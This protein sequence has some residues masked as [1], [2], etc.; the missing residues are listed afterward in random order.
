MSTTI[1]KMSLQIIKK[2]YLYQL[3]ISFLIAL[4]GV[5]L[6]GFI[7]RIDDYSQ[8]RLILLSIIGALIFTTINAIINALNFVYNKSKNIT[9]SF[10]LPIMIWALLL[11]FGLTELMESKGFIT[12]DWLILIL[13]IEPILYHLILKKA[14]GNNVS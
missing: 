10:L 4:I 12:S 13:W 8:S 2:Y 11:I 7:N 1:L 6:L 3:G 14:V 5:N 9:V